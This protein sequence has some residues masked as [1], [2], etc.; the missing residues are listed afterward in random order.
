MAERRRRRRLRCTHLLEARPDD[1]DPV[2]DGGDGVGVAEGQDGLP[3][4]RRLVH[5]GPLV[6]HRSH[7]VAMRVQQHLQ[8]LRLL[9]KDATETERLLR[10]RQPLQQHLDGRT[11]LLRLSVSV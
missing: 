9:G 7:E 6:L 8:S 10:L 11:E 4:A 3:L 2:F 1:G 5:V